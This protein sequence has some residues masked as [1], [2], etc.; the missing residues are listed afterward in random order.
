MRWAIIGGIEI[1]LLT[2]VV[3]DYAAADWTGT[4]LPHPRQVVSRPH[5]NSFQPTSIIICRQCADLSNSTIQY[6][7]IQC[8]AMQ[9]N[10][11]QCHAMQCSAMQCSAVQC[12]A[13]QCSAVQCSA[14][15]CSAM[16]YN[17]IQYNIYIYIYSW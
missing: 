2:R 11:M 6:N 8:N 1:V 16:Q 17:T 12:S 14:V 9:C 13:V 5:C 7:T 10:A 15:Q 3:N 4:A